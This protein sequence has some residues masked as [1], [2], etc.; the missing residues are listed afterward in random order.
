MWSLRLESF[1]EYLG[2]LLED[3]FSA[4]LSLDGEDDAREVESV[5]TWESKFVDNSVQEA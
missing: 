5:P 2:N 3:Y 4:G 1:Q